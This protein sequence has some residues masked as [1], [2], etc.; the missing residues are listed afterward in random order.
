MF[1]GAA[2]S[3]APQLEHLASPALFSA[4]QAAHTACVLAPHLAQN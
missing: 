2:V 3:E 4:P 1:C